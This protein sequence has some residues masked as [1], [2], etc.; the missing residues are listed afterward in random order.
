MKEK[1]NQA[2]IKTG[3]LRADDTY[4]IMTK[5]EYETFF[6]AGGIE[7]C[8]FINEHGGLIIIPFRIKGFLSKKYIIANEKISV[9][10][11]SQ[12]EQ[13]I[14]HEHGK[15][16]IHLKNKQEE[17]YCDAKSKRYH[18]PE[19]QRLIN[20]LCQNVKVMFS[21]EGEVEVFRESK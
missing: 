19:Y 5:K 17:S 8:A 12:I 11:Y 14:V 20:K 21:S 6:N 2:L 10:P 18:S 13:V 9:I 1:L 15:I 3:K 7:Y 16:D 4:V